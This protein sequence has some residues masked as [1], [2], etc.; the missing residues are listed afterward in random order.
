MNTNELIGIPHRPSQ[1]GRSGETTT[2]VKCIML[3]DYPEYW[4]I[5][6]GHLEHDVVVVDVIIQKLVDPPSLA[7]KGHSRR[8]LIG[9]MGTG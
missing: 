4:R 7:C 5:V 3:I 1:T 8:F 9:L 2:T 6:L